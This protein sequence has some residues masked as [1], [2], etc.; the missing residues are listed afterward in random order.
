MK[1]WLLQSNDGAL[2]KRDNPWDPWYD[3]AFT[4]VIRAKSEDDARKIAS[5][6]AGYEA[7][8]RKGINPWLIPKYSSCTHLVDTGD[9]GIVIKDY[10][11]A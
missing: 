11:A 4:F 7:L 5:E 2:R 9:P 10:L 8:W 6:N 3:K 1:L